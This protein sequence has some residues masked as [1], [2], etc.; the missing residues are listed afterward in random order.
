[1]VDDLQ[2]L[3]AADAAAL[4]LEVRPCDLATVAEA[5][6]DSLAS[7]FEHAGISLERSLTPVPILGDPRW[8]HQVVTNLL[9][10]ALK[11]SAA[12]TAVSIEV[13]PAGQD[14]VLRVTDHGLGIAP[15]ELPHIFDRFWRGREAARIS[16]S[17]IGLAVAAELAAAHG[18]ELTAASE[19]GQGTQMTLRLPARAAAGQFAQRP[20]LPR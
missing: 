14:A 20:A 12:G 2:A 11:F 1:M 5:A 15:S 8:L 16:G 3:A 18:G 9:T 17:G 10:N 4:H 7:R 6:A 13:T 19:L